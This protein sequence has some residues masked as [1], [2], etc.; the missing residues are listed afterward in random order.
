MFLFYAP[1]RRL[2]GI[3][4]LSDFLHACSGTARAL[5]RAVTFATTPTSE[6]EKISCI[7]LSSHQFPALAGIRSPALTKH[8]ILFFYKKLIAFIANLF[9]KNLSKIEDLFVMGMT[10]LL[11]QHSKLTNG[12][13]NL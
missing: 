6:I 4:L 7:G 3:T 2:P 8:L 9:G 10:I 13:S 1:V 11:F 12:I 5:A